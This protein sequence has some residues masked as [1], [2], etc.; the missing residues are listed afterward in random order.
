MGW[1]SGVTEGPQGLVCEGKSFTPSCFLAG[2][3]D[4]AENEE[5]GV[6]GG[7]PGGC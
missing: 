1:G 6:E 2:V 4:A 3:R 5:A 7:I